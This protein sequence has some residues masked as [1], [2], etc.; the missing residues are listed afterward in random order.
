VTAVATLP[1][2]QEGWLF[3]AAADGNSATQAIEDVG[4]HLRPAH[5]YLLRRPQ[6]A[7]R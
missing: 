2:V 1:G 7:G 3:K 6:V 4:K 5:A